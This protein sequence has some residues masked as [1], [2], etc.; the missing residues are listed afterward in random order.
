MS[1][2]SRWLPWGGGLATA[3][4]LLAGG[5]SATGAPPPPAPATPAN[6]DGGLPGAAPSP[7]VKV[8]F[9]TV[10][11]EKA[12][13]KW[14]KKTLGAIRGPKKPLIVERPR[15]SGPMDVVIRAQG[16][17]PVHTRAYTFT[18]NRVNV[19]LTPLEEKK[20]LLGYREELPDAGAPDGGVAPA[21][22]APGAAPRDAG[23]PMGPMPLPR[24]RPDRGPAS[25]RI[26]GKSAG[27]VAFRPPHA[28]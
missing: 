2:A 5:L 7:R 18:D 15:D 19:K 17:L 4:L 11:P 21:P 16:F 23:V 10:P 12:F 1:P 14:G 28:L 3:A 13:V 27:A 8:I 25:R 26:N 24:R 9:Q 20:T 22:A 6:P